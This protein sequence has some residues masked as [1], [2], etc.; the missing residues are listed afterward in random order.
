M[1][2]G[3]AQSKPRKVTTA[4]RGEAGQDKDGDREQHRRE[5]LNALIGEQVLHALGDPGELHR[6][7]VFQL[8]EGH[9]RV[10][11]LR[12]VDAVSSEIVHSYFLV[13]DGDGKVVA[14]TPEIT[15]R[16]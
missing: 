12:R 1:T 8:W 4:T 13:A 10:N 5:A 11:V 2:A 15:K 14:S 6:M 3:D 16:Y 9:Y 7:Q